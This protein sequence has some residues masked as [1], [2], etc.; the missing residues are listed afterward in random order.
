MIT[1]G[2]VDQWNLVHVGLSA[3]RSDKGGPAR[4]THATITTLAYSLRY[5]LDY[6]LASSVLRATTGSTDTREG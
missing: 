3:Q 6:C 5:T 1:Q 4:L 2:V